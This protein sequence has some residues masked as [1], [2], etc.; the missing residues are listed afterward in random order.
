G[1]NDDEVRLF[2]VDPLRCGDG[3]VASRKEAALLMRAEVGDEGDQVV[4]LDPA[5]VEQSV[6]FSRSAVADDAGPCSALLKQ[7]AEKIGADAVDSGLEALIDRAAPK[8]CLLLLG[9]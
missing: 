2:L 6:A 5:I 4:A 8:A 7:E 1:G 9:E 3:D